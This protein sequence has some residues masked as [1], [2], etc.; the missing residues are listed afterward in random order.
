MVLAHSLKKLPVSLDSTDESPIFHLFN[1]GNVDLEHFLTTEQPAP[2]TSS[3]A[4]PSPSTTP[5]EIVPADSR[6]DNPNSVTPMD[7]NRK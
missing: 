7:F 3:C 5:H 1:T 6:G 4:Q 2:A